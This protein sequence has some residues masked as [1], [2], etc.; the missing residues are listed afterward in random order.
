MVLLITKII[1]LYMKNK[2]NIKTIEDIPDLNLFMVCDELNLKAISKIPDGFCIRSLGHHEYDLWK[3]FPFD[4]KKECEEYS[5]FMDEYF[6]T[7]F[8]KNS[9]KF[10]DDTLVV[11][12]KDDR[13]IA[14]CLLWKSYNNFYTIQWF[15]VLKEYEGLGIGRAL[16]SVI[17]CSAKNIQY[18]IYLHTQPSSYKAIKLYS[19]FGFKL[20]TNQIIGTRNNDIEESVII[21]NTL[22]NEKDFMNLKFT[23]ANLNFIEFMKSQKNIEF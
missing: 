9:D 13:A 18:P 8:A 20:V 11:C 5:H 19:D 17:M 15:K 6:E 1:V 16:L 3:S 22:M 21:L 7:T 4:T 2:T 14:T 12:D 23:T 10:F